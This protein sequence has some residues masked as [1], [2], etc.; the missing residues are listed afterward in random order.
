MIILF[1]N[2]LFLKDFLVWNVCFGLFYKI[3]KGSGTSLWAHFLHDIPIKMFL[4]KYSINEQSFNIIPFSFSRYQIKCV[5]KFGLWIGSLSTRAA[6]IFF[7]CWI[8]VL[9]SVSGLHIG[10]TLL[11]WETVMFFFTNRTEVK[12]PTDK[13]SWKQISLRFEKE[14]GC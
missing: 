10:K 1:Q 4:F 5:I 9:K 8:W 2:I 14:I 11:I 12:F 7:F 6:A 3:K 13:K